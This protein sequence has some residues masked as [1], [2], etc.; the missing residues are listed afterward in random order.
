VVSALLEGLP[1]AAAVARGNAIG[2][3]VVQFP[4]DSDGLPTREQ[5]ARDDW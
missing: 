4:G 2:A 3:R 5:L 1:L